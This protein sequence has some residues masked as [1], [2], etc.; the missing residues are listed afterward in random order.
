M[1]GSP[2]RVYYNPGESP[3]P[4]LD[5]GAKR[6]NRAAKQRRLR[7]QRVPGTDI[8]LNRVER[9]KDKRARKAARRLAEQD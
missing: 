1:N 9:A 5:Y 7:A 2:R 8:E 4:T 3:R 6:R